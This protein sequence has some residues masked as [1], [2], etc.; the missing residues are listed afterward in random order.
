M[1]HT[2]ERIADQNAQAVPTDGNVLLLA[3]SIGGAERDACLDMLCQHR[4]ETTRVVHVLYMESAVERYTQIERY[5]HHHPAESAVIAVGSGGVVGQRGPE[6]PGEYFVE[7]V[8]DAADLTGLGMALNQCLTEWD[9]SGAELA[10]C[11]DSLSILLQYAE[12]ERVFRFLH[13]LAGKLSEVDATGHF[14]LDPAAHDESE[15]ARLTPIF[16]CVLAVEENGER[17]ITE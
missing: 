11:F 2:G 4:F 6:P 12:F 1:S 3:P 8:T 13:M 9:E 16:D 15:I 10:L 5:C 14:H 7:T 17:T